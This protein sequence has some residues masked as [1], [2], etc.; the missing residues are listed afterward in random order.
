MNGKR[1]DL[2]VIKGHRV[3]EANR[4]GEVLDV[5]GKGD[6]RS[7]LVRWPDGHE[8]WVYPGNDAVI[9]DKTAKSR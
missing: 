8:V 4:R 1:G 5:R 7:Y 6:T 9:E 2:L 3:G